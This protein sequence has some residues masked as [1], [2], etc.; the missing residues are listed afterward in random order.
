M[1]K[2]GSSLHGAIPSR[3][4]DIYPLRALV[5]S[6]ALF[7]SISASPSASEPPRTPSASLLALCDNR[8]LSLPRRPPSSRFDHSHI[9][10]HVAHVRIQRQHVL[11]RLLRRHRPRAQEAGRYVLKPCPL[12]PSPSREHGDEAID[13]WRGPEADVHPPPAGV[14]SY[15]VSLENQ[16]A[17]VVTDLPYE[18]VLEKISKTGKK[19]NSATA[20]G[21]E[22]SVQ[23]PAAA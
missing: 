1:I 23:V 15:E 7:I 2:R 6:I 20:D 14:D 22:K 8:Q 16:T 5:T 3:A 19:V 9:L 4:F 11:R 10:H 18:T 12:V 13:T 21:Q 17:K